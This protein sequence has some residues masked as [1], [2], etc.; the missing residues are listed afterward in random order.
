[1]AASLGA[2]VIGS[3]DPRRLARFYAALLGWS[4]VEGDADPT[5]VRLRGPDAERPGLSVQLEPDF[6]APVW[7]PEP[8]RQQMQ[9][10]VDVLVDDPADLDDEVARAVGLGATRDPHQPA[11]GVV[12]LRDPDG[13]PFCLFVPGA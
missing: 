2:F 3:P 6:V 4:E 1:M 8:G 9:G 7:P 10:H 12:V 5:F 11:E 13:H